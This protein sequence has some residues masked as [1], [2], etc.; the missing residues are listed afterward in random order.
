M[1]SVRDERH[2]PAGR[3]T[4]SCTPGLVIAVLNVALTG[5]VAAG[6]SVV[7]ALFQRWGATVIDA[8]QL[9]REAQAPGMP[10]LA[11]IAERFG[12]EMIRPDGTLDR[13]RLRAA[14][15]ADPEER[16]ALNAIVHPEVYRRRAALLALARA[17]GDAIAVSDIPLLFETADRSEFDAVVLVD[18]PV[19]LRRDRLMR[20][21]GFSGAEADAMLAAQLPADMKRAQSDYVIEN[22]GDLAGLEA[23]AAA[24]WRALHAPRGA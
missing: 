21:R 20:D 10:V 8:D 23:A 6:K 2:G 13:A 16:A 14:V 24:V 12:G 7:A 9:V 18:A 19:S 1:G 17:R 5:N 4:A 15:L 22:D 3:A 11:A